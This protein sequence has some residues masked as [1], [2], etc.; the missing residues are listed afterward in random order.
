MIESY[1]FFKIASLFLCRKVHK[2]KIMFWLQLWT[3]GK[4]DIFPLLRMDT[5]NFYGFSLWLDPFFLYISSHPYDYMY[6]SVDLSILNPPT[7]VS[8]DLP[9]ELCIYLHMYIHIYLSISVYTSIYLYL[10]VSSKLK[11][12]I[13]FKRMFSIRLNV[14]SSKLMHIK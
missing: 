11:L 13:F 14:Y 6:V 7:Y 4:K 1:I 8:I 10:C 3:L 12:N 2:E 9:M 5:Y